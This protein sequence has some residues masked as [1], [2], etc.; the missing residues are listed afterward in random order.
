M[1]TRVMAGFFVIMVAFLLRPS[2]LLAKSQSVTRSEVAQVLQGTHWIS[3]APT[4]FYPAES[5]P[6]FPSTQ[7]LEADLQVLRQAGFDGLITYGSEIDELP[8]VAYKL[9]FRAV[10][11]GVWDPQSVSER[12]N[13]ARAVR[14]NPHMIAGVIVGN[15]GLSTGR[16]T[17]DTLCKALEEIGTATGKPVSTTEP[18]DWILAEPKIAECSTF[19]TVNAHPYFSGQRT[20]E[21]AAQWTLEAW[22]AVRSRYPDA[23]LLF[24]EVGLPSGGADGL[25]EDVQ[26]DYY[27]RLARTDVV[28][29][30][31]EAFDATPRFK[32]A[33]IEQFWGLWRSDRSP[34]GIVADLPWRKIT[35]AGD[36]PYRCEGKA[37]DL[38]HNHTLADIRLAADQLSKSSDPVDLC[39]SAELYKRLGDAKA[40]HLYEQAIDGDYQAKQK[41]KAEP[42]P[43]Y[44][45][46]YGDYL[47][48]YRG[49][50]QRPLFP[51]AEEH[52]FRARSKLLKLQQQ[53]GGTPWPECSDE[54][55]HKC[56]EDRVQRSLTAL[57][58]RDGIHLANRKSVNN[59][60]E[61]Q[62]PWFFFSPGVQWARSTNDFGQ[63]S[64]IRDL[65]SAA[66][67]SENCLPPSNPARRLCTELT[68]NQLAG[69]ARVITPEEADTTLRVRYESAPVVDFYGSARHTEN[70]T[71][72]SS[73][74]YFAPD[75]FA[76]LKLVD[77]GFAVEKP[78]SVGGT[79]DVDLQFKYDHIN[80]E[81]LIEFKPNAQEK[82]SQYQIYGSL[83]RYL[84]PDRI[85]LSY[86]YIRQGINATP[87]LTPRNRE[88]MGTVIDYQLFRPLPISGRDV[89]TGLGRHFAA[90]ICWLVS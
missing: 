59:Q 27:I 57:Y 87:Y 65:T 11:L 23:Q 83:S 34:K 75:T 19:I 51:Q 48:L 26:K 42:E 69:M 67:F 17:M 77:F 54:A 29:S 49:A 22:K 81:G 66:L 85:N 31:F 12:M 1:V 44:E 43:A 39:T 36:N 53:N 79:T 6:V 4:N 76:D 20:P 47:R 25:T 71:I 21:K 38:S 41:I 46:F 3:Y 37:R 84:G 16:Y 58:E 45:L 72:N 61:V 24:K 30:Y 33:L 10:L 28:F 73:G 86:T 90:L 13:V 40:R 70:G 55:W 7:S 14:S 9:G 82:I 18:V 5:P 52:L 68:Q 80:R 56:T 74:G 62:R 88:L 35:Q 78:F 50:G 64:D 63:T 89:N 2:E 8:E 32:D 15:E 60:S